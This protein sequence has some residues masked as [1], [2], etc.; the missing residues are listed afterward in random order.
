MQFKS[1][2]PHVG[3]T[4][5][6]VMSALAQEH[7]AINLSQ[8]FPDFSPDENLLQ[9]CAEAMKNGP[10]QYCPMPGHFRLREIL[11]Q[12]IKKWYNHTIN[13]SSEITITAGATEAIFTAILALVSGGEEVIYFEPAY[14]CYEPAILLAGAKP[15]PVPLTPQYFKPDW[16]MVEEIINHKTRMII[17]N[18]PHNP[19][20]SV[21][22]KDDML[23]L[24][25]ILEK[26]PNVVVLSDEVYEH[27]CFHPDGHQSIWKFPNLSRN[28][29]QVC[30]FGKTLH[31]T[32]WKIGYCAAPDHLM[33][34]FRKVH[35]FNV[36]CVNH[37]IQ[38][39]LANY[40]EQNEE[41][42]RITEMYLKKRDYFLNLMK[43]SR[44]N[45]HPCWGS[46]FVLAD[47]SSVSDMPDIE[48]CKWLTMEHGVAA[49]PLSVFYQNKKDDKKIRFCFAKKEKTL[50]WASERLCKI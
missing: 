40:L 32:G 4:I 21:L 18:N 46:Y 6:T 37:P 43:N 2:L 7:K 3:T 14:D 41:F 10:H 19:C 30:S 15:V 26:H 28:G 47:Y 11:A 31:A 35:Q 39:A 38:E 12:S 22:D 33:N 34:E 17:I 45:F 29:I 23:A 25:R 48:F 13:P 44:F 9:L 24:D 27:I 1:K 50:Q 42:A 16:E 49:I 36:F 20:S 8:G 5:F